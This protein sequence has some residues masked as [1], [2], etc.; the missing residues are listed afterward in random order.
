MNTCEKIQFEL[1]L[2]EQDQA[3]SGSLERHLK[4]CSDCRHFA[5]ELS[6]QEVQLRALIYPAAPD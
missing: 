5:A 2:L 1:S 3:L 6:L 4:D